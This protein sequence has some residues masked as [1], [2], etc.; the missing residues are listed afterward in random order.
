MRLGPLAFSATLTM[1]MVGTTAAEENQ[2]GA[3]TF[4]KYCVVCHGPTGV[5]DG[6]FAD[7][8]KVKPADLTTLAA[9]NNGEF[10]YLGTLR[11]IDGRTMV[12]GHAGMMPVW[13]DVLKNEIGDTAGPYGAE[14]LI[15][16][17]MV[18]LVDYI[19][20]LQK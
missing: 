14:L 5:G 7:V 11:T 2:I 1:L 13:G 15:R 4:A 12:R 19:E 9:K 6:E 10:P 16:A 17:Q 8:L 20:T 18:A 3:E